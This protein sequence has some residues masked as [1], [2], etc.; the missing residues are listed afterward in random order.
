MPLCKLTGFYSPPLP[1]CLSGSSTRRR[2]QTGPGKAE[3]QSCEREREMSEVCILIAER[4]VAAYVSVL[5][6]LTHNGAFKQSSHAAE[7]TFQPHM[8]S[9]SCYAVIR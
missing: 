9:V 2:E 5:G 3:G 6:S 4:L 1:V 8:P 7:R